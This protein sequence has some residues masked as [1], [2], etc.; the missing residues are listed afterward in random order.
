MPVGA[1]WAGRGDEAARRPGGEER[2]EGAGRR[3][4]P[5]REGSRCAGLRPGAG[6]PAESVGAVSMVLYSG[7]QGPGR[8]RAG[9]R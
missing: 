4:G 3:G 7:Q 8:R 2:R 6:R 5:P 1:V 9:E